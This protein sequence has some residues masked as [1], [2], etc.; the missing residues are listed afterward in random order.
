[1]YVEMIT[2]CGVG[3]DVPF[4]EVVEQCSGN[5]VSVVHTRFK[6]RKT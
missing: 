6:K 4:N 5:D 3:G 1:M 2:S